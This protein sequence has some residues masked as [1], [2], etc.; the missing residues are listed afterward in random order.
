M[1][2]S[3]LIKFKYHE[4]DVFW[5][6]GTLGM[7]KLANKIDRLYYEGKINSGIKITMHVELPRLRDEVL[8][9][10]YLYNDW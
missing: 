4:Q 2:D 8:Y 3:K 9:H 10:A 5:D 7:H 1:Q 6:K